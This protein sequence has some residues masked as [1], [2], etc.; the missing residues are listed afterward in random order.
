[1][2]TDGSSNDGEGG[3]GENRPSS[4][5]RYSDK[6]EELCPYYLSLGMSFYD[7]WDGDCTMT[8]YYRKMEEKTRE[9]DN[10]NAW[11]QGMYIYEAMLD[12][13]PVFNPFAKKPKPEPYRSEPVPITMQEF[14]RQE[15]QR[16]KER[17][18]NGKKAMQAMVAEFNKRFS[19]KK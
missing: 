7:Y 19:E 14:K 10:F 4:P 1:M 15:E 5:L 16:K 13:S 18:A 6:F 3:V 8:K 9:R 11:L 2:V 12:V 17:I